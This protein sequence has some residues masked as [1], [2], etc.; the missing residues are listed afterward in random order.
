MGIDHTDTTKKKDKIKRE[1]LSQS[2][3]NSSSGVTH[4]VDFAN[5]APIFEGSPGNTV[6]P[7]PSDGSSLIK[8]I[9]GAYI[10]AP[11]FPQV[12]NLNIVLR[13]KRPQNSP[14]K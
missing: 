14:V 12:Q 13:R 7:V 11:H 8:E 9:P 6:D 3:T 2:K 4:E 5:Q 10:K 1:A